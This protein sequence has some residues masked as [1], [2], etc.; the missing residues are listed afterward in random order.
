MQDYQKEFI[1]FA[2]KKEVLR[3]GEFKL[4]SGRISPYFFNSGL[5]ND[6]ESLYR[7]GEYYA[8][9]IKSS[10]IPFDIIFGP[11]YKGIPL[12]VSIAIALDLNYKQSVPYSF[13]RK[14][15]KDHGEGGSLLGA[16]LKGK[17]LIVDDVITAGTSIKESVGIIEEAGARAAG[18]I[19]ALDRQETG[20]NG[21]S[22][23]QE[24]ETSFSI[25]VISIISLE[26]LIEFLEKS[27]DFTPYLDKIRE[28]Q[29]TYGI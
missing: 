29:Q 1:E 3:F 9:T 14:E 10:G 28:Y 13:N 25:P 27:A 23:I 8:K 2:I 12:A 18:V 4:K 24:V 6:G 7:L 22:A 16:P 20:G 17:V 26:L 11:A 5:F 21:R 19:I 15:E